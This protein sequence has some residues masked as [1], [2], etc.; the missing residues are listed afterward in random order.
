MITFS[1]VRQIYIYFQ[2]IFKFFD[3]FLDLGLYFDDVGRPLEFSVHDYWATDYAFFI[4]NELALIW[5]PTLRR[6]DKI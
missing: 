3:F 5:S 4:S 2:F 1:F 6:K